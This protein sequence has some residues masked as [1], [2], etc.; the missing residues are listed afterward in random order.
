[1]KKI[2]LIIA[3]AAALIVSGC[4]KTELSGENGYSIISAAAPQD[5]T[6]DV[7]TALGEKTDNTYPIIWAAGDCISVNGSKSDPLSDDDIKAHGKSADF[8]INGVIDAPFKAVY[9]L[10]AVSSYSSGRYK[11]KFPATQQYVAGSFDP[12]AAIMLGYSESVGS[13]SFV[14]ALAYLKVTVKGT[15]ESIK[16]IRLQGNDG[17]AVSG[18]FTTTIGGDGCSIN[19]EKTGAGVTIDCGEAGVDLGTGIII[20]IPAKT[21]AEGLNILVKTVSGKYQ[22][23]TSTKSFTALSGKIYTTSFDFSEN[24]DYEVGIYTEDDLIA[25]L[26]AADGDVVC[27]NSTGPVAKKDAQFGDYSQWVASDG[28]VHIK[29]DITLTK[30]V[31]WSA[32]IDARSNVISN[33]DGI[34]DGENHTITITGEYR[35]PLITNLYGTVKNLTLAGEMHADHA[36]KLIAALANCVQAEG[37]VENVTNRVNITYDTV[38]DDS[39]KGWA[40]IRAGGLVNLVWGTVKNSVNEGTLAFGGNLYTE[41]V[42]AGIGGICGVIYGGGSVSL[43]E[44]KGQIVTT[45]VSSLDEKTYIAGVGGVCYYVS[46]DGEITNCTNSANL[47]VGTAKEFGGV[48]SSARSSGISNCHNT[49]NITCDDD[50]KTTTIGGVINFVGAGYKMTGCTNSGTI[51]CGGSPE[52]GGIIKYAYSTVKNCTNSGNIVTNGNTGTKVGGIARTV[53]SAGVL[54]GCK[55]TADI[56]FNA[57][58]AAGIAVTNAGTIKNCINEGNLSLTGSKQR[59]GGIVYDNQ[60]TMTDCKNAGA[61]STA[62]KYNNIAGITVLNSKT[63]SSM[64]NCDNSGKIDVT[65]LYSRCGGVCFNMT[66]GTIDGCDNSA[67]VDIN[68]T[69]DADGIVEFLGGIVAITSQHNLAISGVDNIFGK[70]DYNIPTTSYDDN[71]YASKL[72]IKDCKNTGLVTLTVTTSAS[73]NTVRNVAIGGIVGWNWAKS[74]ADNYLEINNC[75]CG[76]PG[77]SEYYVQYNHTGSV[78]PTYCCPALGGILGQSGPY[79]YYSPNSIAPFTAGFANQSARAGEYIVIDGCK[80][81][82]NIAAL[83]PCGTSATTPSIR[84]IRSLGGIAGLIYGNNTDDALHAKIRNCSSEAYILAGHTSDDNKRYSSQN[85]IGGIAGAAAYVD[86]EGCTVSGKVGSLSRYAMALGGVL[87][88]ATEKYSVT[89]CTIHAIHLGYRTTQTNPYWGLVAGGTNYQSR[90]QGYNSISGSI[91]SNNKIKITTVKIKDNP[92]AVDGTNF[93]NYIISATDAANNASN[94]WLTISGNTWE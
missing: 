81:Y 37:V 34:I 92:V 75:E 19:S 42:D 63:T 35:T 47:N 58:Y 40:Q 85:A 33:F 78:Y 65:G 53:Q 55:N 29:A 17:E 84:A 79:N 7:K 36:P 59:L 93:E 73:G 82:G 24:P 8:K 60:N 74:T 91:I 23:V 11:V 68:V 20:A 45:I 69:P 66:G 77:T 30:R 38:I 86:V 6:P 28:A 13:I 76:I 22:K 31:D 46:P 54:D 48:I 1:M 10:S 41:I 9:P 32:T 61:I 27:E 62:S 90:T 16:S 12:A 15:D 67:N 51:T 49:G 52:V 57:T 44:N 25:F 2:I 94:K 50:N 71:T 5:A 18:E 39:K 21:Y 56:A 87:G 72:T 83:L 4:Q 64:T 70:S 43:C 3:S 26:T 88:S 80:A 89:G 14:N